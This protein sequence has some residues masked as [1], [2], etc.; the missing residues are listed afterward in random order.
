[1]VDRSIQTRLLLSCIGLTALLSV[2]SIRLV[3]LQA[4]NPSDG[5]VTAQRTYEH[6]QTLPHR[7]GKIVDC[8]DELLAYDIPRTDIICNKYHLFKHPSI[9]SMARCLARRELLL[10]PEFDAL[11][12]DEKAQEI[13]RERS[14]IQNRQT[15]QEII[16]AH[17][18]YA[19]EVLSRP[20][21]YKPEELK[22]IIAGRRMEI[23]V[24]K[25]LRE[26]EADDL[27]DLV[28]TLGIQGFRFEK[29][30][31]R[32]YTRP[33]LAPHIIGYVNHEMKGM[34]GVEKF[35]DK[36]LKGRDGHRTF[37]RDSRGLPMAAS[38]GALLPPVNGRN[39]QLTLDARIQS[40]AEE[41]LQEGLKLYQASR[42]SVIV[43]NPHDGAIL[44]MASAPSF[45]LNTKERIADASLS[46]SHQAVYEPGSTF[47]IIAAASALDQGL[48]N[49]NT[50]I[51][52]HW[53]TYKKG[54]V[55][56]RDHGSYGKTPVWKVMAKSSNVGAYK[57]ALMGGYEEFHDYAARF[58]FGE[59]S[60][61][62]IYG[63]RSGRVLKSDKPIDFSRL[64]F[65]YTVSTTPLQVA[66]AYGAIANGGKLMRPML[67]KSIMMPDGHMLQV[68]QPE[69]IRQAV[70][71]RTARQIRKCLAAVVNKKGTAYQATVPGFKVGGKTG[72]ADRL[73]E[74][75]GRYLK[76]EGRNV[77]S[78]AGM[79]P[80]DK[81]EFVCVVVIDDP[82]TTEVPR[83]G[84]HVA[85]PIFS[86]VSA[87]VAHYMN[88][89]PTLDSS[90][91]LVQTTAP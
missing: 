35:Y 50:E 37:K 84:G 11:S 58:G 56:I 65:G 9:S 38:E 31:R 77:V 20:L 62:P 47:K 89:T 48:V 69:V 30:N 4:I 29:S 28:T 18:A 46:F 82:L 74:K 17:Y 27:Q 23:P 73:D 16:D 26:D 15:K 45:D 79:V 76:E 14:R 90:A 75:T 6:T 87:R 53:G 1:M 57:L 61:L 88:L 34:T 44:G 67:V 63:E 68:A 83:Y 40:I 60:G 8:N 24:T 66:M 21:G 39:V 2:L 85:A 51:F 13:R 81:P 80:I 55:T 22:D 70:K 59:R 33:D 91:E 5:K 42:G 43:L 7:R 3:Y 54:S 19:L 72:T 10:K 41:E 12:D 78:F 32:H 36:Y 71:P 25:N 52:C 64:T 49:L 86:K